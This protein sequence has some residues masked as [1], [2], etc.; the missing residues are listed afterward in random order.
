MEMQS[1]F[2]RILLVYEMQNDVKDLKERWVDSLIKNL[3][4]PVC[5]SLSSFNVFYYYICSDFPFSELRAVERK[6]GPGAKSDSRW[7]GETI[8]EE[9]SSFM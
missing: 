1:I 2:M 4:D 8:D 7:R 9:K 5:L 3:F 6:F